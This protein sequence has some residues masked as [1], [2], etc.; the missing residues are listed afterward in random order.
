MPEQIVGVVPAAGQARR[1]GSPAAS[2][3]L[4]PVYIDPEDPDG[5]R[6]PVCYCLLHGLAEAGIAEALVVTLANKVD[7]RE[8]L[9]G[10]TSRT[11]ALRHLTLRESPSPVVS[12]A[13]ATRVASTAIIALG[14]P[15]VLWRAEGAFVRLLGRLEH[16]ADIAL[17]LFP[18]SPGYPT[19]GVTVDSRD[20]VRGFTFPATGPE[21]PRW[22]LAVW[23]S[24]F[25][26]LLEGVADAIVSSPGSAGFAGSTELGLTEVIEQAIEI[27]HRVDGVMLSSEPFFD[28]GAPE[29]LQAARRRADDAAHEGS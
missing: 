20:R 4:E 3:A 13:A 17:G 19:A 12:V 24:T 16:G 8:S 9:R 1:L 5:P 7:L 2:K 23:R 14:F 21:T 10:G 26:R 29:R 25:S 28:I 15:D 11:P 6:L 18:P 22:T 27:G